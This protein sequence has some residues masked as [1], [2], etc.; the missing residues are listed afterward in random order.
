MLP[1]RFHI[2]AT[3]FWIFGRL[4]L[5]YKKLN[6]SVKQPGFQSMPPSLEFCVSTPL[7]LEVI[8]VIC[9][10]GIGAIIYLVKVT[11]KRKNQ[12]RRN[13]SITDKDTDQQAGL[14]TEQYREETRVS[15]EDSRII[16]VDT[17]QMT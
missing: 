8:K 5:Y 2:C 1:D 10:N 7:T 17:Q 16:N 15:I 11:E 4:N 6:T 13:K 9:L 14:N 12:A 3:N